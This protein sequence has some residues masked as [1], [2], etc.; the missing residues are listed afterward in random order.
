MHTS[1]GRGDL[2]RRQGR[3]GE[4]PGGYAAGA[5]DEGGSNG[6]VDGWAPG[7]R[8]GQERPLPWPVERQ[9]ASDRQYWVHSLE[10]H[11]IR[12]FFFLKNKCRN[13]SSYATLFCC[14]ISLDF[15]LMVSSYAGFHWYVF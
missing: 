8:L 4:A 12:S 3:S 14:F 13:E 7:A 9:P 15:L 11:S 2:P 5:G 1:Q 10:S 6:A